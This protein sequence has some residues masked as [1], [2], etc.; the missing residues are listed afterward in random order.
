MAFDVPGVRDAVVDGA[1]GV[2][3]DFETELAA[4]WVHLAQDADWRA[5]L[6]A[7][8]R[9]RA[10]TLSWDAAVTQFLAAADE[11]VRTVQVAA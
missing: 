10:G 4:A 11:A 9:R 1:T 3:V 7:A 5:R 2:L 6:G 8:A